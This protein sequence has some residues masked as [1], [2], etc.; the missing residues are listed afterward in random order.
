MLH[1][2]PRFYGNQTIYTPEFTLGY[3]VIDVN[4]RA[5]KIS[6]HRRDFGDA[7]FFF[8]FKKHLSIY[9]RDDEPRLQNFHTYPDKLIFHSSFNLVQIDEWISVKKEK[10]LQTLDESLYNVSS[11][12]SERVNQLAKQFTHLAHLL[13]LSLSFPL[14]DRKPT[15][16]KKGREKKRRWTHLVQE[17]KVL[18]TKGWIQRVEGRFPLWKKKGEQIKNDNLAES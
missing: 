7:R 14:L 4:N 18:D 6:S 17:T 15:A 10:S 13:S 11:P 3:A 12:I 2:Q 16:G 8:F 1:E 5:L 9:P